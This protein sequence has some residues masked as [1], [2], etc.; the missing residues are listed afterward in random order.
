VSDTPDPPADDGAAADEA[1]P[2]EDTQPYKL[3][4]LADRLATRRRR[5]TAAELVVKRPKEPEAR[6]PLERAE[7]VLGRDPSCDIVLPEAT[8]SQR[9]ARIK[10]GAGGFF[11]IEDLG[12]RNGVWIEGERVERQVLLDGD[13]FSVGDTR[14]SI[15]VADLVG[16]GG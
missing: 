9:H 5:A 15:V 3:R 13:A 11:E 8:A 6:I 12:S 10:K 2:T 7:T 1:P 4:E 14:F 16:D